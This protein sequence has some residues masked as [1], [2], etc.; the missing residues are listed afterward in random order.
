MTDTQQHAQQH[1]Q[2]HSAQAFDGSP[3]GTTRLPLT[4]RQIVAI[5]VAIVVQLGYYITVV[6]LMFST[7]NTLM[8][9]MYSH[10]PGTY[11]S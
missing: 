4:S 7:T 8:Q 3:R 11:T 5:V 10:L 9:N 6:S 2:Q 1:P